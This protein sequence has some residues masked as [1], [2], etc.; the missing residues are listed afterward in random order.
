MHVRCPF[1]CVVTR[2]P[3][4]VLNMC[5]AACV[6]NKIRGNNNYDRTDSTSASEAVDLGVQLAHHSATARVLHRSDPDQLRQVLGGGQLQN[7][8]IGKLKMQ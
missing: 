1:E 3:A 5:K 7:P 4:M 8:A 6:Q 2:N